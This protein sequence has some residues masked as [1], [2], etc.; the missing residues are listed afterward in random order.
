MQ[1]RGGEID[2]ERLLRC[3]WKAWRCG[4]VIHVQAAGRGVLDD[5]FVGVS[6][7][8]H[9]EHSR[10]GAPP[11]ESQLPSRLSDGA[12]CVGQDAGGPTLHLLFSTHSKI[13]VSIGFLVLFMH[14]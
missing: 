5:L 7:G 13:C 3:L 10:P 4:R 1:A 11:A 6:S 8:F 9:I 2:P 14:R 12:S